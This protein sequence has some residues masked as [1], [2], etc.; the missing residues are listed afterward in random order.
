MKYNQN[1]KIVQITPRTLII[2]V[3]I[4]K[5]AH[6]ARVQDFRGLEFLRI[7]KGKQHCNC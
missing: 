7:G 5:F 4:A 3:D 2:G 6:V 1:H